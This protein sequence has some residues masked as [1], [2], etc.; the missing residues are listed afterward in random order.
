MAMKHGFTLIEML[1]VLLVMGLLAGLV[2][3]SSAPDERARLRVEVERLAQLL[4]LAATESRFT[5][6]AVAWTAHGTGYRFWRFSDAAGWSPIIDDALRA[7]SLPAG[8]AISALQVDNM[9]A[10]EA[11]RLQFNPDGA[12][13]SFRVEMSTGEARYTVAG[14]PIGEVR[15][16]P[17]K[18]AGDESYTRR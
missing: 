9:R 16:L 4:D 5:G 15:V 17:Q 2:A 8:M 3:A 13:P 1:V 10:P 12:G 18:G 14:S 7:R 11:M 6:R